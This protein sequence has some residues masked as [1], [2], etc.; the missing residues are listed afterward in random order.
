MFFFGNRRASTAVVFFFEST[1]IIRFPLLM[2]RGAAGDEKVYDLFRLTSTLSF[3]SLKS[4]AFL[5][6]VCKRLAVEGEGGVC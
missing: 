4:S 3:Y 6:H 2:S 5:F 1:G